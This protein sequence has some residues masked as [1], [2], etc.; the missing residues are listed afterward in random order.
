MTNSV[1]EYH[2]ALKRYNKNLL[3][4]QIYQMSVILPITYIVT[5]SY[6]IISLTKEAMFD[7]PCLNIGKRVKMQYN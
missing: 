1:N 4:A 2:L 5:E 3:G 6:G 7:N